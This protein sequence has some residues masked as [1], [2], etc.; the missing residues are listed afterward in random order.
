M[1]RE[2]IVGRQPRQAVAEGQRAFA[3]LAARARRRQRSSALRAGVAAG[4]HFGQ[5]QR[6]AQA[7]VEALRADRMQ[8]LRGI[9][10][11]HARGATNALGHARAM[12]G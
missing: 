12:I 7:Q 2:G 3:I 6:I 8:G 10:H 4:E 5:G 11:Q 1:H 9:A